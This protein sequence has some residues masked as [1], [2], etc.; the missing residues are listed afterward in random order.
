M[1]RRVWPMTAQ[2]TLAILVILGGT[3]Y[4]LG[5]MAC[6]AFPVLPLWLT[7]PVGTLLTFRLVKEAAG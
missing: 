3:G 7:W 1:K 2:Q 5:T 6:L 4:A